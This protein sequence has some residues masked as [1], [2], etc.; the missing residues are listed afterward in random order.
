MHVVHM[1]LSPEKRAQFNQT[2]A[3]EWFYTVEGLPYGY[4]NFLYSWID[5]PKDNLPR[6]L[7]EELVPIVFAMIEKFDSNLTDT[8]FTQSLNKK[9]GTEGLNISGIAAE[10]AKRGLTV[11]EVMA[12]VE[13]DGWKYTGEYHDGESMVCSCFVAALWKN[14]GLFDGEVNAVEWSPKDVYQVDFFN[15]DYVRPQ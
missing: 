5:T 15:K 4:H 11:S 7:P 1:P 2:A 6:L 9:L 10:G 8:F 13:M 14:A 3:E 12:L